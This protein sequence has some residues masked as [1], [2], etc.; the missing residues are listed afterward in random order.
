M[1]PEAI[2]ILILA[3]VVGFYMAWNIGAN[4]VANSMASA[5]GAKAITLKQALIIAG[6]LNFV[7]AAFLGASVTETLRKGIIDPSVMGDPKTTALSLLAAL[8]SASLW[9]FAAT[10]FSMPVSTT[11]SIVGS[12]LGIG[13]L[14]GGA[15]AV[16][17]GKVIGVIGSWIISP[18]F[19]CIIAYTIFKII[20]RKI[21]FKKG[22]L[23]KALGYSPYLVGLTFFIV[24]MSFAL[25]TPVGKKL[26][27]GLLG[28]ILAA[29]CLAAVTGWIGF[30]IVRKLLK[31]R[32]LRSVEDVFRGL[33]VMTS[34]YVAMSQGANDVANA[35]GPL[36]GIFFATITQSVSA[37]VPV[38]WYLL[39]LG[40]MGIAFGVM[41]M[42]R[43]VITTVGERITTLTNTRGFAVDFGAATTVLLASNLGLPVSTTHAAVGGIIGVGLARGIEAVDF[44]VVWKIMLY[45]VITLPI[46]A[47]TC[48]VI[49]KVLRLFY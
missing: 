36:A 39:A 6:I 38:P 12:L 2:S 30:L 44:R 42:G 17:W 49:Y 16:H 25:K 41:T 23:R 46:A 7:G 28:S 47:F 43:R 9:V 29:L 11:H 1:S 19:S 10:V 31:S 21:V 20:Q 14:H 27:L 48:V 33:Q 40:G 34:S 8:L 22:A 4:D 18:L 5:V 37:K 3:G 32:R 24:G 13:I 26:G 35:M 15:G 45:W